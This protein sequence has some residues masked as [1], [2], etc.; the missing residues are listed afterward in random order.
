M[1]QPVVTGSTHAPG[2]VRK[3]PCKQCG[4]HLVFEPGQTVL[5]CPYCG[6][7]E[8]IPQTLEAIREYDLEDAL[9]RLPRTQGWGTER[10]ALHCE[11]CGAVTTFEP[12]QVAGQCAFC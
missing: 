10:R 7:R 8:E 4:A 12:G 5:E 1:A 9:T 11:N 3:F 6:H 2:E